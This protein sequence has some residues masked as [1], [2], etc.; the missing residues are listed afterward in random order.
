MFLEKKENR[1]F[2]HCLWTIFAFVTGYILLMLISYFTDHPMFYELIEPFNA[3]ER[4]I[5]FPL[6]N[7]IFILILLLVIV[8]S[9]DEY[10]MEVSQLRSFTRALELTGKM[11]TE[12]LGNMSNELKNPLT[13]VSVLGKHSY[14]V[15]A[16]DLKRGGDDPDEMAVNK[17]MLD[18]VQDNLRIIVVESDRMKRVVDGLL[19]VAAI[20]QNEIELHKKYFSMPDL[21]QEI[22]KERFKTLNKNENTLKL[23]FAPD[24][25]QVYADRDRIQEVLLN[26]LSNASR[27]TKNGTIVVAAKQDKKKLLMTVSDNGEGIP[28]DLQ[29]SLFNRFLGADTGRAHGTGLGLYICKQ[30]IELHGG[31]IRLESKP[32]KGTTVSIELPLS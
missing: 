4:F 7:A 15:M 29:K 19:D 1:Y 31:I 18:E 8:L 10:I 12:F 32:G 16:E 5:L 6:N 2:K 3:L 14:S 13:S 11:K 9:I 21:V 27:H 24:L 17:H 23:S 25:P 20:E 22:G 26:L 30:I 28:E